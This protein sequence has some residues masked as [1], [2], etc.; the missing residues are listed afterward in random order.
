MYPIIAI[1][2][3]TGTTKTA[4]ATSVAKRTKATILPLDQ[5]QRYKYM[6]VGTG[7]AVEDLQHVKSFGYQILSPWEVSGPGE[8][9]TWLRE[10]LDRIARS[11]PIVI[12]G[13]CTSYLNQL[14][15]SSAD[16]TLSQ[17][18]IVALDVN[19]DQ[20][21]NRRRI[22]DRVSKATIAALLTETEQLEKCGFISEAGLSFLQECERL[23]KHPEHDNPNLAWAIRIAARV[24]CP[25]YLAYKQAISV[26][27]ARS[28][29]INNVLDIQTY[30]ASRIRSSLPRQAL[31]PEHQIPALEEE[32][33]A[34][35]SGDTGSKSVVLEATETVRPRL[36]PRSR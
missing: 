17:I 34:I 16:P 18:T 31:Y 30:Q 36:T 6:Q 4:L 23:W 27:N 25:S 28:R 19:P 12:E 5:L 26:D 2:G 20:E 9:A 21:I 13:G 14:L 3:A 33:V 8:Y 1:S 11:G 24:Y 15:A 7:L 22:R 32:L 29:I 10:S 35:L